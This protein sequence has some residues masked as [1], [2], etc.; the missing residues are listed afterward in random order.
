MQVKRSYIYI[1]RERE[2][3][4]VCVCVC[5]F[6]FSSRNG[7]ELFQTLVYS[8]RSFIWWRYRLTQPHSFLFPSTSEDGRHTEQ[9]SHIL[10]PSIPPTCGS[11]G[12]LGMMALLFLVLPRWCVLHSLVPPWS[13]CIVHA[14]MMGR[15]PT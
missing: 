12:S 3:V 10:R 2:R 14:I 1:Y 4:C 15:S 11:P 9:E 13:I 7:S 5:F 6:S 8:K